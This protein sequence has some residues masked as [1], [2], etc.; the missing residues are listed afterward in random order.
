MT[1]MKH[2]LKRNEHISHKL[3]YDDLTIVNELHFLMNGIR[4]GPNFVDP[5]SAQK[6]A[7]GSRNPQNM[8]QSDKNG[9]TY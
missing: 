8:E 4:N 5:R 9:W 6:Q 1:N 3:H 7:K 2:W